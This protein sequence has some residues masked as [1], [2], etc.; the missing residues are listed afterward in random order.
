MRI[1]LIALGSSLLIKDESS[2]PL[3]LVCTLP[4]PACQTLQCVTPHPMAGDGLLAD[5]VRVQNQRGLKQQAQ[6]T[7]SITQ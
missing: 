3:A 7:P 2:L 4:F 1:H 6:N 5:A